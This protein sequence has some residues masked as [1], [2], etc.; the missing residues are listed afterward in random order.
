MSPA[1]LIAKLRPSARSRLP[2]P[3]E[4]FR[5][6]TESKPAQGRV[7]VWVH[8][9][10][11]LA[12]LTKVRVD[13]LV[14]LTTAVGYILGRRAVGMAPQANALFHTLVATGLV[15]GGAAA[16]NQLI[17]RARDRRM[18]RTR[19][20]PLPAGRLSVPFVG[21]FASGLAIVGVGYLAALSGWP[22]A[23]IAAVTFVAYVFVYTPLKP[24]T[25]LSTVVGAIPGALPPLIGWAA[26][27]GGVS[28][29][30]WALFAILFIWQLPHFLAIAWLYRHDYA[31]GGYPMLT[32][33]DPTGASTARQMIANIV[34]LIPLS[35]IPTVFGESG[36]LYFWSALL[37]GVGFL[38]LAC[39]FAATRSQ[40]AARAVVV[41]SI[42][43]LALV[44]VALVADG[45]ILLL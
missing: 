21:W 37:L 34:A 32:V 9:L 29:T 15:A 12:E 4:P 44:L 39:W 36:A 41:G 13:L 11:D 19:E 6:L 16:W 45:R 26:A 8:W 14:L 38:L 27:T 1:D 31:R 25:H 42:I 22:A 2:I 3:E 18:I 23:S 35:L 28:G 7:L 40:W 33:V 10:A 20:R 17:E 5:G 24:V 30:G 43:Y